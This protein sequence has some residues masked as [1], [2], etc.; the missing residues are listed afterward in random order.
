M[1]CGCSGE[2]VVRGY[3]PT[4][5]LQLKFANGLDCY[6]VFDRHQDTRAYQ[7]LT[8]LGFI[9]K[10]GCHVGTVPMAA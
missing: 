10:A 1:C 8:G 4:N 3:G 2:N 7:Y 5:P 9:A 6:G